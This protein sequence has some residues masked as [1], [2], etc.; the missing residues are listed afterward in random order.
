MK[1]KMTL[2]D[3]KDLYPGYDPTAGRYH[4]IKATQRGFVH[5][6]NQKRKPEK[7]A[8]TPAQWGRMRRGGWKFP[9]N[10]SDK[11]KP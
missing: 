10:Y 5:K 8:L 2:Q 4:P 3:L 6:H 7:S 9:Y 1:A 11:V